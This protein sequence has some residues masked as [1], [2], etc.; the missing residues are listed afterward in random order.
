M[1]NRGAP[2]PREKAIALWSAGKTGSQIAEA[3]GVSRNKV[4]GYLNRQGLVGALEKAAPRQAQKPLEKKDKPP[5]KPKA[6]PK[7]APLNRPPPPPVDIPEE[8]CDRKNG[9]SLLELEKGQCRFPISSHGVDK[10]AHVFC[11]VACSFGQMYCKKH[12]EKMRPQKNT[13]KNTCGKDNE[14]NTRTTKRTTIK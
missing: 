6:K 2:W 4:M 14:P 3:L 11:G 8:E 10:D 13:Q 9:L 7:A 5:A 12:L 1:V